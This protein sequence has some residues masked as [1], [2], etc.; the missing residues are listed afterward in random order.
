MKTTLVAL[1]SV[2]LLVSCQSEK[3]KQSEEMVQM[4]EK[5]LEF[6][7]QYGHENAQAKMIL[8]YGEA[9]VRWYDSVTAAE[10]AAYN[11]ADSTNKAKEQ[12]QIDSVN[13]LIEK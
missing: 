6:S 9:K 3:G 12:H 5:K 2:L 13:K 10:N 7:R 4:A 8:T 1:I 11:Y